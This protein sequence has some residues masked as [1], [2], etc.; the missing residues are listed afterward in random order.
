MKKTT[1]RI[2]DDQDKRLKEN[3]QEIGVKPAEAIRRG[4]DLYFKD[5][6]N[7]QK[8]RKSDVKPS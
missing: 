3:F 6:G 5:K 1:I 4:I 7:G 8:I 2:R